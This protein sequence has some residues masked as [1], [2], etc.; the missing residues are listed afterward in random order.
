MHANNPAYPI[1]DD[2]VRLGGPLPRLLLD[3]P[4]LDHHRTAAIPAG[5][6]QKHPRH[7]PTTAP[8]RS[9]A[10]CIPSASASHRRVEPSTSVNRNVTTPEGA[11]AGSA[12]A[13]AESH[14]RPAPTCHIGGIRP[15][16]PAPRHGVAAT[17]W[18]GRSRD[19]AHVGSPAVTATSVDGPDARVALNTATPRTRRGTGLIH[20]ARPIVGR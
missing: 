13:H 3:Q 8:G 1:D 18:P 20:D 6:T 15:E 9:P 16:T 2:H 4:R 7:T 19:M 10:R 17:R 5:M 11:A 12:D 14:N